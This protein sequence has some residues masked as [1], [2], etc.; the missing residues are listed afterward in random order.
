MLFLIPLYTW[1]NISA[2]D[3]IFK[4]SIFFINYFEKQHARDPFVSSTQKKRL[5]ILTPMYETERY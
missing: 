4:L 2:I 5:K 3:I 1:F